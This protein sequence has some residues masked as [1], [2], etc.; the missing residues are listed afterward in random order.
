MIK[1]ENLKFGCEFEFYPNQNLEEDMIDSLKSL[2]KDEIE[3]KINL[4]L[5]DDKNMNYKDEPSLSSFGGKEITTPICT[6]EDL[7]SSGVQKMLLADIVRLENEVI[8]T[9]IYQDKF[10][11]T[12]KQSAILTEKQKTFVFS[13]I[14]YST[15]LTLGAVLIGLS[16]SIEKGK[17]IEPWLIGGIGGL[18]IIGAII[19]KVFKK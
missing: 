18:L 4:K 7:K 19:T 13:E 8:L 6:D 15:S 14:L 9:S 1:Y 11:T 3:L 10:H 2:L 12:D 16:P 17:L 5:N